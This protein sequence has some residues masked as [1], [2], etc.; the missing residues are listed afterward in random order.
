LLPSVDAGFAADRQRGNDS[1]VGEA[2]VG[3]VFNT[4]NSRVAASYPVDLFGRQRRV[5]ESL[6]AQAEFQ[7]YDLR[8]ARL[9]IAANIVT[10]AITIAALKAQ[11]DA[12]E[13]IAQ[14][15]REILELTRKRLDLGQA[16]MVEVLSQQTTLDQTLATVP[17][18]QQA[19]F[20]EIH[21]LA[22][23]VGKAPSQPPATD[24]VLTDLR[25]PPSLPLE[26]PAR[27]LAQRPDVQAQAAL[28]HAASAQVG[29]ATA[30]L[31]PQLT[32]TASYGSSTNQIGNT[33]SG[34][35]FNVWDAG[36]GLTQP[37]FRGG[38]LVHQRRAA[39]DR[40]Q[41]SLAQYQVTLLNALQNVAQV[42]VAI[43]QDA[44]LL[45]LNDD[46]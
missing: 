10:T 36:A 22:V 31:L 34:G 30:D 28:V 16:S 45:Q 43:D 26:L 3:S 33:F 9:A 44:K 25:L 6:D 12:T 4:F 13:A 20:N 38:E 27:V 42:L 37:I 35:P 24:W 39:Q 21:A 23:L 1:D 18:L 29:V 46:A 5:I 41:Q 19:L 8:A 2:N 17:P 32:I 15:D 14:S 40:Y 11:I 7:L